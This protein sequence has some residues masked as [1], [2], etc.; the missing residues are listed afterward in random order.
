[1]ILYLQMPL[2]KPVCTAPTA[3]CRLYC[4]GNL[5]DGYVQ[6]WEWGEFYLFNRNQQCR[7]SYW[8]HI[9]IRKGHLILIRMQC[10]SCGVFIRNTCC[11]AFENI[12][13][14]GGSG[15]EL[16]EHKLDK[17]RASIQLR[18]LISTK[19]PWSFFLLL[20][21]LNLVL[22]SGNWFTALV[23]DFY[24]YKKT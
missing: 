10:K 8:K 19:F 23:T 12:S 6:L 20:L 1:M 15:C 24:L 14:N 4:V 5:A 9:L 11:T 21:F 3:L 2:Y 17:N 18:N 16:A 7:S 13:T 22:V